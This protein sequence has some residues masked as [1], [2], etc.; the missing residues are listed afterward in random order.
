M[1]IRS[2]Q[3][4]DL[5]ACLTLDPS[6]ETDY[7]WQ[8]ET[9][10]APGAISVGFRVTR[11]PRT[12]RVTGA[13]TREI[14]LEH[15]ERG[16]CFLVAEEGREIRGYLDATVDLWRHVA[17][18]NHLTVA[19]QHRRGG[20]GSALVRAALDWSGAQNLNAMIGETQT[21]NFPASALLQKHGFTF[22]GF[23]DQY[24]SSHD[25]AIFFALTLR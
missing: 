16:E 19:P 7:V 11:L 4:R 15:L 18:I 17:W 10:R 9:A 5:D 25:I 13:I 8:M 2:A 20:I 21:K 6:Y 14:L 12:M 23:N 22:C 24:Y 1:N 3:A